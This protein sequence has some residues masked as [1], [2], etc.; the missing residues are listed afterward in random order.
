MSIRILGIAINEYDDAVL[1]NI[2]NC[3]NDQNEILGVLTS[4]YVIADIELL[5]NK[6]QTTRKF[7]HNKLYDYFFNCAGGDSILLLYNGHGQYND[8]L[9][10]T[11]WQTSDSDSNDASSWF[12]LNDLMDFIRV[13][14]AFHVSVI[15][16][17]CFS[18][19]IFEL[20]LRG[21][22]VNALADKKS[23]L[24]L[25][26]GGIEKVSDG[27]HNSLSPFTETVVEVLSENIQHQL[28]FTSFAHQVLMKFNTERKQTPMF[29]PLLNVGHEGGSLLYTLKDNIS[30]QPEFRNISLVLNVGLPIKMDYHCEIP[31]FAE[32]NFF[33]YLFVNFNV[34]RIA[35]DAIHEVQEFIY[36]DKDY[37]LENSKSIGNSLSIDYTITSL[38]S[39]MLSMVINVHTYFGGA[40]PNFYIRTLN[41]GYKPERNLKFDDIFKYADFQDFLTDK[42]D[43]YSHDEEQKE[44]L[45]QYKEYVKENEMEFSISDGSVTVYFSNEMPKAF[46]AVGDLT[47]PI[48]Q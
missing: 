1:N 30:V 3:L 7:L 45:H 23:R 39:E 10:T 29:G 44:L 22:G 24:A 15:S 27:R 9:Q 47:F 28:L 31:L 19:A 35:F 11:Y 17:S 18:G 43:R 37:F 34:Q 40:Y 46:K 33:D 4:K 13:S 36:A 8:F 26:A 32:N 25:T 41:I 6:A 5:S 12:N 14:P 48:E 21:G 2:S 38:T 20:P 42:I 16:N